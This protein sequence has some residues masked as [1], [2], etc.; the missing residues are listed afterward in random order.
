MKKKLIAW[1]AVVAMILTL[2]GSLPALAMMRTAYIYS[3]SGGN[4]NLRGEPS[5][6]S[7][8]VA[9]MPFGSEI[10]ILGDYDDGIWVTVSYHGSEGYVM[11]RYIT[12]EYPVPPSPTYNPYPTY[13]PIPTYNPRPAPTAK[14]VRP[15][16]KPSGGS[17]IARLFSGFQFVNYSAL[18]RPSSPG[19]I[20]NMRWAPS[21]EAAIM[22]EYH[23][24]Y[25]LEVIAMNNEWA[26][27]RDPETGIVGFM[28]RSLM[29]IAV[30]GF[31][32]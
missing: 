6:E 14:P 29:S 32:F 19:G 17:S 18:V 11:W 4:V 9:S 23:Q 8:V 15:T 1:V 13:G 3:N 28:V 31:S 2:A 27:V 30:D 20:V 24:N 21:K 5:T 16:A 7:Y 12:Y 25:Q 26:Q 22:T 10:V